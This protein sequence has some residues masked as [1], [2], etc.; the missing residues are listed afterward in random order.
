MARIVKSK[1]LEILPDIKEL[2][3]NI[4]F[5]K[6]FSQYTPNENTE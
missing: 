6:Y 5:K 4:E 1:G 3:S 2:W